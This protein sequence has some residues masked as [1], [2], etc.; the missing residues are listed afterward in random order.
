MIISASYRTVVLAD[1]AEAQVGLSVIQ[2]VMVYV[3]NYK[4]GRGV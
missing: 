1:C 4:T 2:A 3:V